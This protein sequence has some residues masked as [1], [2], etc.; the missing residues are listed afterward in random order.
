LDF[1]VP[2]VIARIETEPFAGEMY[3]GEML[4]ALAGISK[5]FWRAQNFL[6]CRLRSVL[7]KQIDKRADEN[8]VEAIPMLKTNINSL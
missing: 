4:I 8:V 3:D 2:V 1:V 6:A 5:E 7:T